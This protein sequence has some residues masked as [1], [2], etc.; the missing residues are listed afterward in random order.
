MA[1]QM[2]RT[3]NDE[4]EAAGIAS[5]LVKARHERGLTQADLAE[6]SGVSRSAI[7]GYET[8]RTMPGSRELKALCVTLGVSPTTLLYGSEQAFASE[9]STSPGEHAPRSGMRM[10]W[11][12]Q[13]LTTLL[14]DDEVGALLHLA[15]SIV[16]ARHG[17]EVADSRLSA[18]SDAFSVLTGPQGPKAQA[19]LGR[20]VAAMD[21][22]DAADAEVIDAVTEDIRASRTGKPAKDN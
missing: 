11:Q 7:K 6:R 4:D 8:G 13:T 20:F 12:L 15:R 21:E 17:V 5:A 10:R 1:E 2:L 19:A 16:V 14:P 18:V 3:D 9:A 22:E